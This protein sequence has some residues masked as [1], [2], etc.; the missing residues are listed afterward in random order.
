MRV[1]LVDY[2]PGTQWYEAAVHLSDVPERI[3]QF[4]SVYDD[5]RGDDLVPKRKDLDLRRLVR[6]LPDITILEC[7]A[8]GVVTYRLMGT[9]VVERMGADLT[10][11]NCLDFFKPEDRESNEKGFTIVIDVPCAT[12]TLYDNHYTSGVISKNES[13][14]VPLI[15]EDGSMQILG[16]HSAQRPVDMAQRMDNTIIGSTWR[17]GMV[18]DIGNGLPTPEALQ[19]TIARRPRPVND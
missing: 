14:M 18:I 5:A 9:D 6:L 10:G 8:P 12:F 1:H 17:D 11:R 19:A 13:L 4:F 7:E 3:H 15:A 16:Y 2:V